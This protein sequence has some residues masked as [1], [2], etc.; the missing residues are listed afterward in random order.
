MRVVLTIALTLVSVSF[1]ETATQTDWSGGDEVPGP[2]TDWGNSY[3]V[4]DQINDTG[5]SLCLETVLFATPVEHTVDGDFDGTRSVYAA[6]VD[7]DGD[8]DVLGAALHSDDITWWENT[9]GTGTVWAEHTVDG[10]FTGAYSVFAADVDGDGDT[11]VLG[12]AYTADDIT[13]WDVKGYSAGYLESSILDAGT[14][15]YWDLFASDLQKPDGTSVG[16]QFRSSDDSANMGA[17]SDTVFTTITNLTN[18]LADTT[19]FLQYRVILQT[20]DTGETPVLNDVA[21]AY[22]TY[23]SIGDNNTYEVTDWGLAPA[24]NPSLGNFAVQVSVPL[25]ATINLTL[26]DVTGRLVTEYSQEL[27]G[28]T[29]T[30]SFNNIAQGVYFCTM[31]AEE[32]TAT[33]RIT[34]LK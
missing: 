3:D 5:S 29:H 7:G 22:T 13:W 11:D 10:D 27:P 19:G 18:I 9:D 16:F 15:A 17:W 1:S 33:E 31:R 20:T 8:T 14:V 21:V 2:V 6:D 25:Q 4:A 28:G 23:V 24:A 32:F 34:V 30:V 26:H 12:A